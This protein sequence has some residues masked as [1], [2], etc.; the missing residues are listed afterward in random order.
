MIFL[1]EK[2]IIQAFHLMWGNFPE[3]VMITQKSREADEMEIF[4]KQEGHHGA[5][6]EEI[7]KKYRPAKVENEN[8]AQKKFTSAQFVAT[9][10]KAI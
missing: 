9:N 1:S 7:I 10:M 2:E 6:I 5:V 8:S 4:A 3:A